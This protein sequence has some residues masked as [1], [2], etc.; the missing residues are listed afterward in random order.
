MVLLHAQ[1]VSQAAATTTIMSAA[2][3]AAVPPMPYRL[4]GG[5]GVRVAAIG[6]GTMNFRLDNAEDA[7]AILNEYVRRGG[8]FIDTANVYSNGESERVVGQWLAEHVAERD[9]VFLATKV[10]FA[11]SA[12][13]QNADGLS[14]VHIRSELSKQLE[15]LQTSYVDLLQVRSTEEEKEERRGAE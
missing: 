2:D 14:R 10:H 5:S 6:L 7:K 8:N 1:Q 12:T 11:R 13:K 4:L 9:S 15:R 3:P